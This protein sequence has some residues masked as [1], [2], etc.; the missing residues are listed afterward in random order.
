[1]HSIN[2]MHFRKDDFFPWF[3]SLLHLLCNIVLVNHYQVPVFVLSHVFIVVFSQKYLENR[4]V[5]DGNVIL[6]VT[7][8]PHYRSVFFQLLL[9]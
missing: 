6:E 8:F 3:P 5:F 7:R 9:L 2:A 1:M 4:Q